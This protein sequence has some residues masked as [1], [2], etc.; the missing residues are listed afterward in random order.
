MSA[1]AAPASATFTSGASASTRSSPPTYGDAGRVGAAAAAGT[2]AKPAAAAATSSA[3]FTP[4][5][6]T[7]SEAAENMQLVK[8]P[9]DAG[10][11]AAPA[12]TGAAPSGDSAPNAASCSAC[13]YEDKTF[14]SASHRGTRFVLHGPHIVT[15]HGIS[16]A[17]H[18]EKE[19]EIT[20]RSI[21]HGNAPASSARSR[22]P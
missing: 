2:A 12:T 15:T 5:P 1:G 3:C 8:P 14:I 22:R 17:T 20:A 21:S 18:W 16:D 7:A 10:V 13:S 11:S 19:G 6:T 9:I 4:V